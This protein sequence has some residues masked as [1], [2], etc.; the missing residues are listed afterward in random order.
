MSAMLLAA[1]LLEMVKKAFRTAKQL[2]FGGVAC[3]RQGMSSL[4]M[5]NFVIAHR[6]RRFF[7]HPR[8]NRGSENLK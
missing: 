6:G 3:V 8:D 7:I 2:R 4:Q 1:G 5:T